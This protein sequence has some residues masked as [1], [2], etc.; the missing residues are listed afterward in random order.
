MV[1]TDEVDFG[2]M[3]MKRKRVKSHHERHSYD[4]S[5]ILLYILELW[6][7]VCQQQV[8]AGL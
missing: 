7:V 2:I 1:L 4:S 5:K 8:T 6:S 3:K